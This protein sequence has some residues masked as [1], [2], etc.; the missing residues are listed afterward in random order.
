MLRG[1]QWK[2]LVKYWRKLNNDNAR[3]DNEGHLQSDTN[4]KGKEKR[5]EEKEQIQCPHEVF[6]KTKE[7]FLSFFALS[8][9]N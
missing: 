2:F 8:I 6:S 1:R 7:Y 5:E 9:W 4:E 3:K